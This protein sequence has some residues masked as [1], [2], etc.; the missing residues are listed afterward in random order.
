ISAK[1]DLGKYVTKHATCTTP[2]LYDSDS[3]DLSIVQDFATLLSKEKVQETKYLIWVASEFLQKPLVDT[4][5]MEI[6]ALLE[7]HLLNFVRCLRHCILH[8]PQIHVVLVSSCSSWRLRNNE[9][10]YCALSA[11]KSTLIRNLATEI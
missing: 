1:N 8:N 11:A 7:L 6:Y 2:S 5:E 9:A 4:T 3:I 10:L